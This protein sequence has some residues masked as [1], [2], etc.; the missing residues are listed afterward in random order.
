MATITKNR[1]FFNCPL[2]LY[3]KS[4][5]AQILIAATYIYMAVRSL[6]Y[7]PG[8]SVKF[9][10]QL[11]YTD[12]A[13]EAYF[14]IR[15]HLNLL[16]WNLWT[17]LNQIWLGGSL[18][19]L[20]LTALPSIQDGC[21]TKNRNFFNCPLLLYYKSKWAQILTAATLQRVVLHIIRVFLL[22]FSFS[23]FIQIMQSRH[24]LIKD[25]I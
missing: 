16:F 22:N 20:C 18:S 23:R 3:Y 1:N 17:K 11:I 24:I 12:Y 9:F 6:T 21:F 13:N 10:F 7:I 15:S 8:F 5:W 4:K 19:K 25:H 14:D 2:L